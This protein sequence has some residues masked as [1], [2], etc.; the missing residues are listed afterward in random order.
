VAPDKGRCTSGFD[1]LS[2]FRVSIAYTLG[3]T[4]EF[5]LGFA[6]FA[7]YASTTPFPRFSQA[8]PELFAV[9]PYS[10]E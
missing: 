7:G 1:A 6:R 9:I 3:F 4:L 5:T 10:C 8:F 2:F